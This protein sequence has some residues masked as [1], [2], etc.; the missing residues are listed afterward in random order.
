MLPFILPASLATQSAVQRCFPKPNPASNHLIT[1]SSFLVLP[2]GCKYNLIRKEQQPSQSVDL[3]S[4]PI[5]LYSTPV[6]FTFYFQY[7]SVVIV[8]FFW[9]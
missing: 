3:D 7:H 1:A 2:R 6:L 5:V 8:F 4:C 9:F